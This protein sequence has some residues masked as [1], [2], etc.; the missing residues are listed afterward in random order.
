VIADRARAGQQTLEQER[1]LLLRSLRDLD[2]EREAGDLDQGDYQMLRDNYTAR[3]A[4]VLRQLEGKGAVP[5]LPAPARVPAR[6]PRSRKRL[7]LVIGAVVLTV[8]AAT[9]AVVAFSSG[10]SANQQITGSTPGFNPRLARARQLYASNDFLGAIKLYDQVLKDEPRQPEALAYRGWLLHLT[11][12]QAPNLGY[13]DDEGLSYIERAEQADES[14]PDAHLF[15]GLILYLDHH[16]AVDAITELRVYLSM[17]PPQEMVNLVQPL[18]LR[19]IKEAGQNVPPGPQAPVGPGLGPKT[20]GS[21]PC[22]S[23]WAAGRGSTATASPRSP[24]CSA[25]AWTTS[26]ARLWRS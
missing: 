2:A 11:S 4:L 13:L 17:G 21:V 14:Y 20:P 25:P 19:A 22:P 12:L 24:T 26:S 3:A 7:A 5:A 15:R 23:R 8:G 1:D 9:A 6:R 10:R 16:D 18:L